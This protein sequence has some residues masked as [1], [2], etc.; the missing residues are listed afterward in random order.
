VIVYTKYDNDK[1]FL[2]DSDVL[3]LFSEHNGLTFRQFT[4]VQEAE[5]YK[6]PIVI[7]SNHEGWPGGQ[8]LGTEDCIW[9]GSRN[10]HEA[11]LVFDAQV[12]EFGFDSLKNTHRNRANIVADLLQA[13]QSP[14]ERKLVMG[15]AQTVLCHTC[16]EHEIHAQYKI[17][18]YRADVAI[19]SHGHKIVIE[20]DGH[21]FH[22]RTK[23]QAQHDKQRD[24]EMQTLGW[25]VMRFTGS[26]VWKDPVGC[27]VQVLNL[28]HALMR[29]QGVA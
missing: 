17:G 15:L 25:R 12:E 21:E 26:E 10:E 2:K 23:E 29:Q 3:L 6:I 8:S 28:L 9:Y 24:R 19:I 5:F 11:R 1:P 27:A 4:D 7:F 20:A 14:I 16:E 22:E 18:S 13:S